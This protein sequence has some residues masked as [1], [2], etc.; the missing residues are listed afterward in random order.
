MNK[1]I[2]K[3]LF[4]ST[5][6]LFSLGFAKE[7]K[8]PEIE[9]INN[10][11]YPVKFVKFKMGSRTKLFV[12]RDFLIGKYNRIHT[13]I[14]KKDRRY[15]NKEIQNN[16]HNPIRVKINKKY[17]D[18]VIEAIKVRYNVPAKKDYNKTYNIGI[19]PKNGATVRITIYNDS[20]LTTIM[21]K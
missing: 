14:I 5:F 15:H 16:P 20:T 10:S 21:S 18:A 12:V 1:K 11:S 6:T 8:T 3:L 9:I 4:L 13:G 17:N 19:I 2:F 7:A